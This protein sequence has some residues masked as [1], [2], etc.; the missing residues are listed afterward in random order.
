MKVNNVSSGNLPDLDA[1]GISPSA[2]SAIAPACL[3][4]R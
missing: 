1:L 2:L 4:R 3:P